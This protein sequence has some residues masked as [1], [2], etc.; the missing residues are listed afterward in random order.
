MRNAIDSS[1]IQELL[2]PLLG[3]VE[4]VSYS[5]LE[6]KERLSIGRFG[7][8][9]KADLKGT[10]VAVKQ[11]KI[12][13]IEEDLRNTTFA[14]GNPPM[15]I[16][17]KALVRECLSALL[18][19]VLFEHPNILKVVGISMDVDFLVITELYKTDM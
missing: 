2:V 9:Y 12:W 10:E 16:F 3:K 17:Y 6:F 11:L 18:T 15:L 5:E 19:V 14:N 8:V 4:K 7:I 1:E 13:N